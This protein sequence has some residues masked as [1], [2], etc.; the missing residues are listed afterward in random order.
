MID[1]DIIIVGAGPAGLSVAQA[2]LE[3]NRKVTLIDRNAVVGGQLIKQT[4]KFFGSKAQYA[5]TRGFDIAQILFEKVSGYDSF[6]LLDQTTAVG[7]YKDNVL[8]TIKDQ[9]YQRYKANA[10]IIA[11]GA[12]EKFLAFENNDL[13]GIIGAGAM[14]TLLNVHH[15]AFAK[16]V[17]MVG[18]GN[19]GLIVSY[20]LLQANIKVK[21]IID[22]APK[23]GG[24]AVHAS[25]LARRQV[26][27]KTSTT[28][29]RAIGKDYLE[30]VEIVQ[31]DNN[32]QPIPNTNEI[33][34]CDTCC[35]AVGLSP[36]ISLLSM[37]D[38]Q[39]KYVSTLGGWV[40]VLD[41]AYQTS[42][43]GVYAVGDCTKIEEASSA[44][45]EGFLCGLAVAHNLD[46]PHPNHQQLK[47]DFMNQL[48][49]LRA[50][51]HGAKTLAGLK[52]LLEV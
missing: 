35:I 49:N 50:G 21:A 45:M 20:Q 6:E 28:I 5:S 52:A 14:Q 30:A 16:E 25:K 46:T 18:S 42:Q 1:K 31:V 44:M 29:L 27:I 47:D 11:T 10:I 41:E 23:I 2:C 15:V 4:H 9:T 26:P 13:P 19:I 48:H 40:P 8:T 7:L 51:P 36:M 39:T 22:A 17:V 3:A 38:V 32:Y 34:P 43:P 12:S 37:I 24:Y 33:I